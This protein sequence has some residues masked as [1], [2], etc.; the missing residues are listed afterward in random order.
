VSSNTKPIIPVIAGPT[1]VGKTSLSVALAL[2]MDAEIISADSRQIYAPFRIGTAR[3]TEDEMQGVRHHLMGE[4]LLDTP[5]S[6]GRF[7]ERV[8]DIIPDISLRGKAVVAVGGSTLYVHAL[9]KGL[10]DIPT[11]DSEIRDALNKELEDRGSEALHT[12][13]LKIDPD[14]AGTL[15]PTKSQRILRG[16]EVYRGTGKPLSHFHT[17]PPLPGQNY[18]LFVLHTDRATLY[19]RIDQRVDAMIDEGLA[20]EF[21]AAWKAMPD[22]TLNA[23]RTIGYQELIPWIQGERSFEEAVR[24]LKRNSKRYAKRQLTWYKR[25][26]E[27]IWLDTSTRGIDEQVKTV[28]AKIRS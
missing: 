11:V 7:A 14:F 25:Y 17:P 28:L 9:I 6:A 15:D 26:T 21:R 13:L 8:R 18:Q 22:P 2:E 3:P 1:A 16:L 10:S 4:L 23:W 19:E 24:L 27:A 20:E 5:Y 12:E